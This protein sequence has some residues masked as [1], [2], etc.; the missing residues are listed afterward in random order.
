[1]MNINAESIQRKEFHIVFKGYKPEEV[2]KFLDI[3]A[4]E[5]DKLQRSQRELQDNLERL[6]YEGDK[7]S[8]EMKRVIQEALVSA[9]KIAE[10]IKQKAEKEAEEMIRNKVAE[11]EESYKNLLSRKAQLER[12]IQELNREYED[13][14]GKI[15]KLVDDFK[16]ITMKLGEG[17]FLNISRIGKKDFDINKINIGESIRE[18]KKSIYTPE[19][20]LKVVE[21]TEKGEKEGE[22]EVKTGVEEE[23]EEKEEKPVEKEEEQQEIY[24]SGETEERDD[25]YKPKRVKKKIDIANPD[26]INDFFKTD[27]E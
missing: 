3:L 23:E 22:K 5:F 14:K 27:E 15:S 2:D 17:K 26:I 20:E 21:D 16:D 1:M 11:E 25:E 9:H 7:E 18:D 13:F 8:V 24:E 19:E 12:D 10:D 6:R 4:V